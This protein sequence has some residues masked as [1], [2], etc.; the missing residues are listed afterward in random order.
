MKE[1]KLELATI[2]SVLVT[3]ATAENIILFLAFALLSTVLTV[4]TIREETKKHG[5]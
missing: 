2:I 3:F 5:L 1:N 4:V